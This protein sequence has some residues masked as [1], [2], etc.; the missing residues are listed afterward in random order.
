MPALD[1]INVVE[2]GEGVALGYCGALLAACGA[3]V[4]K[5]ETPGQGD[6]VRR[7]PPFAPDVPA[8]E[9]SGLHAFLSA[10]K[11]SVAINLDSPDGA[12]LV[13]R[14]AGKADIVL[15]AMRPGGSADVGLGYEDLKAVA[16]DLIMV[17]LSWFGADGGRR[18]WLGSDGVAQALAGFIYPIGQKHGPPIIPGGYFAQITTGLTAFIATMTALIGNQAGDNGTLID[19]SIQEAQTTYTE[20]AGVRLAYGGPQSVRKGINKFTPTYP[21][22]IYP[23]SDGWIG[24]TVLTPQQWRT[25]CELIGAPELI[26]DPRFLT[27]QT[28]SDL[29]DELD[30]ILIPLFA[31]RPALE[32]F[33]EGQARRVPFAM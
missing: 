30:E 29:A 15:D 27:A 9:A 33:H 26:D 18:D 13:Q 7:L 17:A 6:A 1:G 24:V 25:C 3:D 14:L 16:P 10:G 8:P 20:T 12:A 22:T 5:I 23:A 4:I 19:L 31:K 11:S 2:I 21:Q 32:W 28:R